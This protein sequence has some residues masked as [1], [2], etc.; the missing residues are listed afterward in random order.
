MPSEF[1]LLTRVA[2][3]HAR[4]AFVDEATIAAQWQDLRFTAPPDLARAIDEYDAFRRAPSI[5]RR[6][7]GPAAARSRARP[8]TQSTF[9]TRRSSADRGVI[10]AGMGKPQR[11]HEPGGAGRRPSPALPLTA[12]RLARFA[13]RA[14]WRG[15]TWCGSIGERSR[16]TR[17][18]DQRRGDTPA[19]CAPGDDV[20]IIVVALPH[21]R[22][23]ADVMHLMSLISPLDRDLAVVYSRLLPVPFR[24]SLL[25]S[26]HRAR[27]GARRGVRHDGHQCA[28]ARRRG[29]CLMLSGNPRTRAALERAGAEVLE[30]EGREISVKG[31][32]GPD[33]PHAPTGAGEHDVAGSGQQAMDLPRTERVKARRCTFRCFAD[34]FTAGCQLPAASHEARPPA[35][36]SRR[37]LRHRRDHRQHDRR[38]HP[39]HAR[40]R[41]RPGR[42]RADWI[43]HVDRGRAL[44]APRR[45]GACRTWPP[46]F[47]NP[48]ASTF[49]RG[50]HWARGPGSSRAAPTGS[51]TP[52]S[53]PTAQSPSE[54]P[55][56][57][58]ARAA[59]SFQRSPPSSDSR[60]C[61]SSACGSA[62]ACRR[63]RASSK[64]SRSSD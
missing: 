61:S 57:C 3:K 15:A 31:A 6:S 50:A 42:Q 28:G 44:R 35:S 49:T 10:L 9:A 1:G 30:Y 32:G 46:P 8:S 17:L 29:A 47:R 19:S 14:G 18:P 4:D 22:G 36:D 45:S 16:R 63:S 53:S 60:F 23:E 38:W 20:E 52:R 59:A 56:C 58:S 11:A 34:G 25:A 54:S 37:R 2:V 33:V 62:A 43:P 24:E 41:R 64:R 39:A 40:R 55:R 7:G 5:F 21:W 48:G 26:R 51:P 27:R 13:S 12:G